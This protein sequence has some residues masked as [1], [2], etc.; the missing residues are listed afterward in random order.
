MM[1]RIIILGTSSIAVIFIIIVSVIQ[2][3]EPDCEY[4][5]KFYYYADEQKAIFGEDAL[6][7]I[8]PFVISYS[9]DKRNVLAK[10]R[11][12]Y[13]RDE[14]YDFNNSCTYK[15]GLKSDYY[16]IINLATNS[17]SGPFLLE[18]FVNACKVESVSKDLLDD[19]LCNSKSPTN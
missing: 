15:K 2:N 19:F 9:A 5:S 1:K 14:M 7:D 12:H 18:E 8:P 11:P 4:F 10:Q 17:V 16:W 3:F 13:Y 6:V